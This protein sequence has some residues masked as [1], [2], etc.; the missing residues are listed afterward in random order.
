MRKMH[1]DEHVHTPG[2]CFVCE[3]DIHPENAFDTERDFECESY[4]DGRKYL[5]LGC[6]RDA[7]KSAVDADA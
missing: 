1:R 5:C 2:V 3:H 6:V 7:L 4:L